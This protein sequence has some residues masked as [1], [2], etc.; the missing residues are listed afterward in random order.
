MRKTCA[1]PGPIDNLSTLE[2]YTAAGASPFDHR[3]DRLGTTPY[4][5]VNGSTQVRRSSPSPEISGKGN[6]TCVV[7]HTQFFVVSCHM[8][9]SACGGD[10][11][12][13]RV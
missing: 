5:D 8:F 13:L 12:A 3:G 10:R 9:L 11:T 1:R 4:W 6:N 7:F 2:Y